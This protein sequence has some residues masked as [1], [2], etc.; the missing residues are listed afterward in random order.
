VFRN[1]VVPLYARAVHAKEDEYEIRSL[2]SVDAVEPC[3]YVNDLAPPDN[4]DEWTFQ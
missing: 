4:L 2:P 3:L 1:R